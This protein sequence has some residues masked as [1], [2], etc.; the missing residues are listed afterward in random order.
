[1]GPLSTEGRAF[2]DDGNPE[3]AVEVL[4]RAVAAGEPD[5]P[6]LLIRAYLESGHW[7]CVVDWLGPLVEQGAVHYAGR[8]GVALAEIGDA[9]DAEEAFRTAVAA[10]EIA[11][12]ND[13]AILL[14]DHDRLVEAAHLL[15]DAAEQGDSQA[16]ANLSS[17]LLEAGEVLQAERAAQRHLADS[18]PDTYT[19][20]A[21]VRAAQGRDG[22]AEDLYKRAI[23]LGAVR[24]HTAYASF[25]LDVRGDA[26]AGEDELRAAAA[27]REPD[28]AATLGRFLLA[29]GRPDE[30]REY[31]VIAQRRGDESVDTDIAEADG[32]D[33]YDD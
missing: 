7:H 24:G 4:R 11:A 8:L 17:L 23:E 9:E 1:M 18:R 5:G 21:D 19:A 33:P 25:L 3:A 20:L 26:A 28:W 13:L 32:E 31:L 12:A 22:E 6:D 16:G 2:L 15:T 29:D 14:R 30:A 10:G 27:A